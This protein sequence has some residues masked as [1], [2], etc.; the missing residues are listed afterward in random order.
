M[1]HVFRHAGF[2]C[3]QRWADGVVEV[4]FPIAPTQGYLDAVIA[5][6]L[7]SMRSRLARVPQAGR[8]GLGL[9][10]QTKAGA[11]TVLSACRAAG[12]EVSTVLVTDELGV[13]PTDALLYLALGT[14]CDVVMV[15]SALPA[16]A[17]RF[18]AIARAGASLRPVVS[19]TPAGTE[20]A[21]CRQAGA[22]PVH[23]VPEAVDWAR[24]LMLERRNGTWTPPRRGQ[25]VELPGC[26]VARAR[27]VLDQAGGSHAASP[28]GP[29]RLSPEAT[30]DVLAAYGLPIEAGT[31]RAPGNRFH[32][33]LEDD[34][35]VGLIARAGP[36][37][38]S[39]DPGVARLLPLTDRD[40]EELVAAIH[41]GGA[42]PAAAAGVVLRA[43]RLIDDQPDVAR[44]Q[45]SVPA[46]AAGA[47]RAAL[48][49]GRVRGTEDDP[50]VRRV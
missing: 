48:W 26:D 36:P 38:A 4:S 10:C 8:G 19:L 25:L 43:A 44:V 16:Q 33:V 40:A 30:D 21:W 45:L 17:R 50:F 1:Q 2:R 31:G 35:E 24:K 29:H 41:L 28:S 49:T 13:A 7:Q 14:D 32:L 39:P 47:G 46:P 12:V 15:A 5:R 27:A 6:E 37:P 11:E 23:Q 3:V 9:A 18:V 20:A 22:D 34:P 42:D